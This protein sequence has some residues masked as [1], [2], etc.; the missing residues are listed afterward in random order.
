MDCAFQEEEL[1]DWC[2]FND[3]DED[4]RV[5]PCSAAMVLNIFMG[6]WST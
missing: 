3:N 5:V 2:Y 4:R 6:K 1:D